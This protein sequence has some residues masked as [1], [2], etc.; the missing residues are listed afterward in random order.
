MKKLILFVVSA[1]LLISFANAQIKK[2]AQPQKINIM[3][4]VDMIAN[5]QDSVKV[6]SFYT[7]QLVGHKG[8]ISNMKIKLALGELQQLQDNN[9][10]AKINS[11]SKTMEINISKLDP[12]TNQHKVIKQII[13]PAKK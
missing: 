3:A 11:S 2:A 8:K 6:D 12:M 10:K 4:G 1:F 7:F 13:V 5:W 9:Y